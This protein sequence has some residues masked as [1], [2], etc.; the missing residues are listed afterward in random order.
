M[1]EFY[2][3]LFLIGK[4]AKAENDRTPSNRCLEFNVM[5]PR[6]GMGAW[7]LRIRLAQNRPDT[8]YWYIDRCIPNETKYK[9]NNHMLTLTS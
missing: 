3:F 2:Q 6:S 8:R 1:P 5:L 7:Y 9:R 4:S